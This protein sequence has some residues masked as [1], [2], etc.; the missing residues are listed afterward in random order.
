MNSDKLEEELIALFGKHGVH[1]SSIQIIT[2]KGQM[3]TSSIGG[4]KYRFNVTKEI[5]ITA[6]SQHKT[7]WRTTK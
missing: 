2:D 1:M 4:E 6:Y 7:E 3:E 5:N